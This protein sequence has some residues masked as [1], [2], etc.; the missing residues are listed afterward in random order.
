MDSNGFLPQRKRGM[1]FLIIAVMMLILGETVLR[2]SLGKLPFLFYWMGCFLFT[3][4]AIL[5]A[6]LDVAGV[7]RQAREQQRELLEKTINE[8]ARQKELKTKR[9]PESGGTTR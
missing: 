2:N 3:G 8:I 9:Q 7:Q 1:V 5:F 4:L 6:F